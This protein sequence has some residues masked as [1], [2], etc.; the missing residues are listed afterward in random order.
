MIH[1]K[2]LLHLSQPQIQR[3]HVG[4]RRPEAEN[5]R[6]ELVIGL[7]GPIGCDIT[8]AEKAIAA[9]LKQVDY[10]AIHI[11]LSE[12]IADLL[13]EKKEARPALSSLAEKIASGNEVRRLYSK[14]GILAAYAITKVREQRAEIASEAGIIP[15][16]NATLE[17]VRLDSVA[18]IVRQFKRPE[19]IQLMRKIYG[20]A[21]IQVS[22]TQDRQDRISNLTAR[23]GRDNPSLKPEDRE[24]EAKKLIRQDENEDE[25]DYGQRLTKIFH[26]ADAFIDAKDEDFT[27]ATCVR[28]INAFF[29]R[30]NVAPTK[31]EFGSYLAKSAS[32]RSVD[33]SRQVGA[34]ILSSDGDVITIGCNEVPKPGGG[35]YWDEDVNKKRDIDKG[36]EANK[37]E[38]SRIIYDF[39][40][41]LS[42][43]DLLAG[44]KKPGD[45]L[46]D[47][48]LN[49]AISDSMIGE[50]TEYG[51]MIHAEMNAI[52]DAARLGRSV[53]GATL[54]VTTFPC[55]NCAK[56]IIG[57]GIARVIF[58]EPYPKS[59]TELLYGDLVSIGEHE[60]GKVEFAHF[61]GISPSRF[62][63]I[64]EKSRRRSRRTGM[65][66]DWHQGEC[67]PRIGEQEIDYIASE[68]HAILDNFQMEDPSA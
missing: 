15:P 21:F 35:N 10:K 8:I 18:Y 11:S 6:P 36:G 57:C 16:E 45:I 4:S 34:A 47:E 25:D 42:D 3:K 26:L 14:N 59:R 38:T 37:E 23:L 49:D 44:G 17:E 67:R 19:E 40:K 31:D 56:H 54:Y 53:R 2:F 61:S 7:V 9:A 66:E 30:N 68:A 5:M 39:L 58:I 13:E 60:E 63:S 20:P 24:A 28:F 32:L 55:H 27:S 41:T 52:S 65:I 50:I 29:G 62:S 12:G 43:H 33:L 64:F 46:K 22:V 1:C 48:D 51:R